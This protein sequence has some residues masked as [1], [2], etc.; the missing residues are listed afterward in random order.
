MTFDAGRAGRRYLVRDGSRTWEET[1]L[2]RQRTEDGMTLA[3]IDTDDGNGLVPLPASCTVVDL[4]AG[5]L[6]V[7]RDGRNATLDDCETRT[8][9]VQVPVYDPPDSD[10]LV[11]MDVVTTAV[12]VPRA[13]L[14]RPPRDPDEPPS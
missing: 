1:G 10:N 8:V 2:L 12:K 7:W 6:V 14:E 11:G 13:L 4:D 5:G 9:T 3:Y